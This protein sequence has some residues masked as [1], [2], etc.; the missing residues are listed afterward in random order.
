[1]GLAQ[2]GRAEVGVLRVLAA[3]GERDLAGMAAQ[4]VAP[5]GEDDGRRAA[6]VE[7]QRDEHGRIGAAVDVERRRLDGVEEDAVEQLTQVGAPGRASAR[8]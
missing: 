1:V 4:V 7:E 2:R 6:G 3:A 5:A 8:G